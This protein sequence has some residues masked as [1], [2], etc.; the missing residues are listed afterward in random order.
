MG[1]QNV[2]IDPVYSELMSSGITKFI[3]SQLITAFHIWKEKNMIKKDVGL[4]L[5]F[6]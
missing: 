5:R 2:R 3:L 4:H 6:T 1:L